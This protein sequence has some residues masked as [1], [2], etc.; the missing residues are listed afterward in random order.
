MSTPLRIGVV[1]CGRILNAHFRGWKILREKGIHSFRVTALCSRRMEDAL[2]F[3]KRGEGPTPRAPV[4]V[5]PADGLAA[6]H[7]YVSD[8][9]D[10]VLPSCHTD[11]NEILHDKLVDAVLIQTPHGLH[12]TQAIACFE[13]GVHVFIEK[14]L[15]VT[16]EAGRRMVDAARA[17]KCTL[18]VAEV[19]RFWVSTRATYW[20]IHHGLIGSVQLYAH[21]GIGGHEWA[22][23]VIVART[24]WRLNKNMSGGG[25]SVDLGVHWFDLIRYWIGETDIVNGVTRQLEPKR[26]L[27][28]EVGRVVE[29][30]HVEVEDTFF[31][32]FTT[33]SGVIGQLMFSWSGHGA[34]AWIEGGPVIWGS[35]G[36]IKGG[37]LIF[38]DGMK[39]DIDH[40]F[41]QHAPPALQE[42]YFPHG[43]TDGFALQF[44]DFLQAIQHGRDPE[45]SGEEGLKDLAAAYSILE[46]S[47]AGE[48]IKVADVLSGKAAKYQRDVDRHYKLTRHG[49]SAKSAG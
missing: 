22:P 9:Q 29:Q 23:D 27:R 5:N 41:R 32:N 28:D 36:C 3:R 17:N 38:D 33:V 6:D 44:L 10:D 12:H 46:S 37:R 42:K 19:V 45:V 14:P 49:A 26:F 20:A 7:H 11:L 8:F 4:S 39:A 1:G 31:A 21:G 43:I 47:V 16:V 40:Y 30:A 15:A 48:P 2:M 34:G 35:K 13:N 18:G 25:P 24:P